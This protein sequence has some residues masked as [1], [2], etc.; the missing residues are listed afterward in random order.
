M[1]P[2]GTVQVEA[3]KLEARH[4]VR[5]KAAMASR[6]AAV[7]I[8]SGWHELAASARKLR[9]GTREYVRVTTRRFKE[10]AAGHD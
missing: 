8:L 6:P 7:L 5:V 4:D 1:R 3:A 2:D 10:V 9:A